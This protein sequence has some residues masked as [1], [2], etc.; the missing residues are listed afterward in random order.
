MAANVVSPANDFSNF[1]PRL[2]SFKTGGYITCVI[3]V[4]IL[5]WKLIA[6]PQGYI[7]KWLIAYSS[8]LGA[9]AGVMIA[10]YYLIRKTVL[11]LEDLFKLEGEYTYF[12]GWNLKAFFALTVGIIPNIPGFL[13]VVGL[14]S[15]NLFS[16]WINRLY[17]Y[18]WFISFLI[19]FFVYI[20]IMKNSKIKKT[21][22]K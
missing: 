12:K 22:R 6:D 11:N 9:V 3:G 14:V 13:I 2:I 1:F 16:A 8:L 19:S 18:A 15:S 20:V 10:D 17:D 21:I 5:P 7:F 4:A